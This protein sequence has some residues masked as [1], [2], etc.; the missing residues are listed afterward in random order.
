MP[1]AGYWIPDSRTRK[2]LSL[3]VSKSPRPLSTWIEEGAPTHR[4]GPLPDGGWK[5]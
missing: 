3:P 1:G 4:P 2:S 5:R